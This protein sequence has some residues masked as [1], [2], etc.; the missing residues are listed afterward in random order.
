MHRTAVN[1]AA[2]E[3][4]VF[5]ILSGYHPIFERVAIEDWMSAETNAFAVVTITIEKCPGQ[6]AR[7]M[8]WLEHLANRTPDAMFSVVFDSVAAAFGA[9]LI[10]RLPSQRLYSVCYYDVF[11]RHS[12]IALGYVL[13]KAG[14]AITDLTAALEREWRGIKK[15][16]LLWRAAVSDA[17]MQ[18]AGR[19]Q[20]IDA[21]ILLTVLE[22]FPYRPEFGL[23]ESLVKH[24]IAAWKASPDPQVIELGIL[25]AFA[26]F[27]MLEAAEMQAVKI[28]T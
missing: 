13:D 17:L 24:I 21:D 19:N 6:A 14:D 15:T 1:T 20:S 9:G 22:E 11:A 16:E 26:D 18:L 27:F 8:P 23:A 12:T 28:P 2:A 7:L 4:L 3:A 10:T 25:K 5:R